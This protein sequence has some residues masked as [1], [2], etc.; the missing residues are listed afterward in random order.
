MTG[1]TL[2]QDGTASTKFVD[3]EI[4]SAIDDQ[5]VEIIM[6]HI[7]FPGGSVS[8]VEDLANKISAPDQYIGV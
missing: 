1:I 8:C 2:W 6:L 3:S 5:S 7:D 4:I